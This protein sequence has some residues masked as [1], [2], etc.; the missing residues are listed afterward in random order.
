MTYLIAGLVIFLGVH[1]ISIVAW[2]WRDSMFARMGEA[3]WKGL[4]SAIS[5]V[6]FVLI[7]YGYGVARRDPVVLYSPP[8]W[9]RH[10]T[11]LLMVPV[12]PAL[13]SAYFP[14]RIKAALKHPML[15]AVKLWAFAHLL[16]NGTL[17][18]VLLFGSF[19]AWAVAD[20]VSLK[21]RPVRAIRT[22]PQRPVNDVI[23]IGVGLA[24]YVVFVFWL[25]ALW[26]GVYPMAGA[27][28]P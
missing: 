16:A 2:G 17:A 25:H 6:G 3:A 4:Y 5:I 19:L 20:R 21:R 28:L 7:V 22:A 18:D 12:F 13:I 14:G 11:A 24:L 26:F 27:G 9:M 8:Y 23:A 10:V 1:S 15:V